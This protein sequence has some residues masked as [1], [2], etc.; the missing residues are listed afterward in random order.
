MSRML[1]IFLRNVQ[2]T[3]NCG[4]GSTKYRL[5]IMA[6][7]NLVRTYNLLFTVVNGILR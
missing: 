1:K 6:D 5:N 4:Q 2:R 7:F 3:I